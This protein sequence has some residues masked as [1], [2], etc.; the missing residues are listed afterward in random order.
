MD[1]LVN[2][3]ARVIGVDSHMLIPG[4]AKKV[5]DLQSLLS[6]YP[7]FKALVD[8]GRIEVMKT[9]AEAATAAEDEDEPKRRRTAPRKKE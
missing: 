4:V 7:M 9:G 3:T 2:K 8:D 1:I 5:R 6:S